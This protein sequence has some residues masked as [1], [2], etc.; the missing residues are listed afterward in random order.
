MT[1]SLRVSSG[2][3]AAGTDATAGSAWGVETAGAA[4]VAVVSGTGAGAAASC[5]DRAPKDSRLKLRERARRR[6]GWLMISCAGSRTPEIGEK[7]KLFVTVAGGKGFPIKMPPRGA[8][9]VCL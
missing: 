3:A 6:S 7:F 1:D 4:G 9:A 2:T 8:V 5:A